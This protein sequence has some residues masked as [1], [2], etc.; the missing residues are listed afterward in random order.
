MNRS[1]VRSPQLLFMVILVGL[2]GSACTYYYKVPKVRRDFQK[3]DLTVRNVLR[4][5]KKGLG[6]QREAF[7]LWKK[8]GVNFKAPVFKDVMKQHH[9]TKAHYQNVYAEYGRLKKLRKRFENTVGR[10]RKITDKEA[11]YDKVSG[12]LNEV[13]RLI[14]RVESFKDD[15]VEEFNAF[16]ALVKKFRLSLPH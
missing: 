6:Q 9:R 15:F 12:Q 1:I 4:V 11:K 16:A 2:L 10:R 7:L 13:R 8:K 14:K 5:M 3:T